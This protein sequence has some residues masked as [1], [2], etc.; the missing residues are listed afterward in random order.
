MRGDVQPT[1]RFVQGELPRGPRRRWLPPC[2]CGHDGDLS[3]GVQRRARS[4]PVRQSRR[5]RGRRGP[6]VED[7]G[8]HAQMRSDPPLQLEVLSRTRRIRL[9]GDVPEALAR[10]QHPLLHFRP[11]TRREAMICGHARLVPSAQPMFRAK[12]R[13]DR[14]REQR[15][16]IA[17]PAAQPRIAPDDARRLASPMRF[18]PWD[19]HGRSGLRC[20]GLRR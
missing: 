4:M 12:T 10:L 18:V 7:R 16:A 6:E 5:L 8:V 13:E 2:L 14:S 9:H 11:G 20:G 15:V 19:A 17:C 3:P 1:L